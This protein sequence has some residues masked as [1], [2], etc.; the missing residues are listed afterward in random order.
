MRSVKVNRKAADRIASGH[1]WIFASDIVE[2]A[3]VEAGE[4]V[5]VIDFRIVRSARLISVVPHKLRCVCCPT[6]R[7][8]SIIRF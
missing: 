6:R 8:P 2:R 4:A 7:K 3:G 1:P 5:Q